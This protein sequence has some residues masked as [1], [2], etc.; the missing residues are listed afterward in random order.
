MGNILDGRKLAK[1]IFDGIR[2][3]SDAL[4]SK[5]INPTIAIIRVGNK[6]DDIAYERGILKNCEKAGINSKVIEL[7]ENIATEEF[8]KELYLLNKDSEI[9]GILIFRPL[10]KH[11]DENRIK[12]IISPLKDIDCMNPLNI[13]K[14]FEDDYSGF[15][16]CTPA[17]VMEIIKDYKIDL[18]GKKTVVIG[19][20]IVVG[21]PLSIMLLKE[22]ATVTICHSKTADLQTISSEA[23]I[24]IA[25]IGKARF[26]TEEYIK[27]G[28]IVI[29]VGINVD[30]NGKLCGDVDFESILKK[31]SLITPVPG[32]VGSVT[33]AILLRNAI[34]AAEPK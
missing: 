10:P 14:I 24:L 15:S 17:A 12:H 6:K 9:H 4:K 30:E 1:I 19:R 7:P 31:A 20:S 32:G 26:V 25:A 8:I 3:D 2:K 21:K 16:P 22:N 13:A 29:D 18:V 5:K 34:I 23:D 27:P 11:L 33:T 28:G